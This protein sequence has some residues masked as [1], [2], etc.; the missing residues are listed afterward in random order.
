MRPGRTGHARATNPK[1]STNARSTDGKRR[2]TRVSAGRRNG[3]NRKH[4]ETAAARLDTRLV[5]DRLAGWRDVRFAFTRYEIVLHVLAQRM[6][7]KLVLIGPGCYFADSFVYFKEL[8]FKVFVLRLPPS[9]FET[10][11]QTHR[12]LGCEILDMEKPG[13]DQVRRVLDTIEPDDKTAFIGG[14]FYSGNVFALESVLSPGDRLQLELLYQISRLVKAENTGS[15]CIR[16]FNGDTGWASEE[17]RNVFA[18][19]TA[20]LDVVL[21]DNQLLREFVL[22]NIPELKDK[23]QLICQLEKPLRRFVKVNLE[24]VDRRIAVLGR[25]VSSVPHNLG[26]DQFIRFPIARKHLKILGEKWYFMAANRPLKRVLRD[27]TRFERGYGRLAFG[28]SHLYDVFS[29]SKEIFLADKDFCFSLV[30]QRLSLSAANHGPYTRSYTHPLYYGYTNTANK[31][32]NCLMYGIVPI[33]PHDVSPFNKQLI[34]KGMSVLIHT[35]DELHD[36]LKLGDETILAMKRNIGNN[37]ELF[38][39]ETE[40]QKVVAVINE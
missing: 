31:D 1:Q 17:Q 22:Y 12:D 25:W 38:T 4:G 24:A 29:G 10:N 35:T 23:K 7:S 2:K 20:F 8:G 27:R 37:M 26:P 15:T 5:S 33:L 19:K 14:G 30:G 40:A 32:I 39:F 13:S 16:Y 3:D 21:F 18:E 34:E 36:L 11:Y 28:L 9:V 6:T